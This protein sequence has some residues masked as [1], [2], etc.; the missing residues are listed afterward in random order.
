[1][2]AIRVRGLR[3]TYDAGRHRSGGT[4]GRRHRGATDESTGLDSTGRV[5]AVRGIDLTVQ[6]G[7]ILALLGP[8]GAGK[9]TTVEILEGVR[10]RD[11]GEVTV[12]GVDPATANAAWRE[13][14]GIVWQNTGAFDDLTVREVVRHFAGLY[15]R[16]RPVDELIE[17]VG[18]DGKADERIG[19]LS[20]GQRRRLD[21][22]L[23]IVGRPQLLFL[24][25]P[26][27]GF[28]PAARRHFWELVHDL[29]AEGTTM[30]LTTHYLEEA[31]A[32]AD[33]VAVISRG[34]IV[35][36][37]SPADLGGR[38]QQQATVGWD[39][40]GAGRRSV[41]TATP[42][43]VV[44]ELADRLGGEVPGLDIHRPTLEDVYLRLIGDA[45][46]D[47]PPSDDPAHATG[48]ADR[49]RTNGVPS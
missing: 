36:E 5:E 31:E 15:R 20:G 19:R 45:D 12:L 1:M 2:E 25:E 43:A 38:A 41:S 29:R 26:T 13:R 30:V 7:E 8:N 37:G 49:P 27:T 9:T 14:V 6:Q 24:D 10:R 39:E 48:G 42:T 3:K 4:G 44:C 22:A 17:R 33:R 32:L 47:A 11:A 16:P 35:A 40:P 18:L 23:G 21:V 46:S 28:D 34:R